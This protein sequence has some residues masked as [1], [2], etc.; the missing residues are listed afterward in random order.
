MIF[1]LNDQRKY[2]TNED[3]EKEKIKDKVIV[4]KENKTGENVQ[5]LDT[6]KL[7]ILSREDFLARIKRGEYGDEYEIRMIEGKEIP[8]SKRDGSGNLG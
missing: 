7:L 3:F 4:L 5:F 8:T 2:L 1:N 6:K